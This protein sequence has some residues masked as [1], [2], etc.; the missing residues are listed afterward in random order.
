MANDPRGTFKYHL[1]QGNKIIRSG[2]TNDLKRREK[3][4]QAKYP[5]SRI[6][7]IGNVTTRAAAL[8]WEKDEKKGT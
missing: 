2:V 6:Q 4:H 8:N 7:K 3:E 1:K 5:G